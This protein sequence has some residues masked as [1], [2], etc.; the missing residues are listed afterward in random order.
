MTELT[1]TEEKE[2]FLR[3]HL[4]TNLG[5]GF[6]DYIIHSIDLIRPYEKSIFILLRYFKKGKKHEI[7]ITNAAVI[8]KIMQN[9]E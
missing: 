6:F 4:K 1:I 8:K 2:I 9:I 3:H 5:G 7:N